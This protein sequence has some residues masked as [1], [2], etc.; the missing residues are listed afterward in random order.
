MA[1]KKSVGD[2]KGANLKSKRVFVRVDLNVPIDENLKITDDTRI[3]AAVPMTK[4]VTVASWTLFSILEMHY[5][6]IKTNRLGCQN[7]NEGFSKCLESYASLSLFFG[8]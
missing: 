3:R 1:A 2:L 7:S 8:I 5:L 4:H 6:S